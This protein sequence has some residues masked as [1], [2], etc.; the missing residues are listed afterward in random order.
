M[1]RSLLTQLEQIRRS[2]SYNDQIADAVSSTIA[3]PTVSGSLEGDLNVIRTLM[4]LAKG[5]TNWYDD[6]GNYFDPTNTTSGSAENK[7]LN[8]V[9]LRNNSLDAKTV[10]VPVMSDNSGSGYSVSG[11][12]N[13]FLVSVTTQY[14]DASDRRGLP[15]FDS[16]SGDYWDEG[17]SLDVCAID[18]ISVADNASITTTSGDVVYGLFHDAADNG[19][20]GDGTDVYIK[21]YANGSPVEFPSGYEVS[22]TTTSG[23]YAPPSGDDVDFDF[24]GAYVTPS[25]NLIDFDFNTYSESG[26]IKIIY[27]HRRVQDTLEE[28]EWF[29]TDFITKVEG[30]PILATDLRN[31][32][33]YAGATDGVDSTAGTWTNTTGNYGLNSDEADLQL[34]ADAINNIYGDT[35]FTEDN[36]IND[37]DPIATALDALDQ[38]IK[39][40]ADNIIESLGGTKYIEDVSVAISKNIEHSLPAGVTYTPDATS[41][42]EGKNMDVYVNGQLVMADTGSNGADANRDYG[43]TT[44]S[45][46]TFRFDVAADSNLIYVIRL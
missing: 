12:Q 31:L 19:G 8:L 36:Y 15:I 24:G 40:N 37:G 7:T 17:G 11:T 33:S 28:Y 22:T 14:A 26:G 9:N 27:P 29:R 16:T 6:L 41:G 23:G 38:Q 34:A 10:I 35:T 44:T 18:I 21:F 1:S 45:G 30:D 39:D 43:E 46:V 3:E 2:A 4:R 13:G 32:I 5:S 25:G 20:T 42:Q